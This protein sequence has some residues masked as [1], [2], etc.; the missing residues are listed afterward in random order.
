MW[1]RV[2]RCAERAVRRAQGGSPA[3][4]PPSR[5]S[6]RAGFAR[7][8]CDSPY[9]RQS[10]AKSRCRRWFACGSGAFAREAP[11]PFVMLPSRPHHGSQRRARGPFGLAVGAHRPFRAAAGRAR[12]QRFA[13]G[14]IVCSTERVLR[15]KPSSVHTAEGPPHRPA[16]HL[17]MRCRS[18]SCRWWNR[19]CSP[20]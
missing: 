14:V 16:S 19:A 18:R 9:R 5:S 8:V 7:R 13:F 3:G 20:R 2:Q 6:L 4:I 1:F 12:R 11:R 17:R 10:R 15:L